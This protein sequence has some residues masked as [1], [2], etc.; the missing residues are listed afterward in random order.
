[1]RGH[2]EQAEDVVLA[3]APAAGS[4]GEADRLVKRHVA[5]MGEQHDGSVI[6]FARDV[7]LDRLYEPV[8]SS[9]CVSGP[10]DRLPS[11]TP[12]SPF[13]RPGGRASRS[14]KGRRTVH[15]T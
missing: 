9:V 2:R 4:F 12:P 10:I 6:E 3:S 5:A 14:P 1:R 11:I 13:A 15:G 7:A 8:G